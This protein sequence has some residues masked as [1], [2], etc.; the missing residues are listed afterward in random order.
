MQRSKKQQFMNSTNEFRTLRYLH[1]ALRNTSKVATRKEFENKTR[2]ENRKQTKFAKLAH[3]C[4]QFANSVSER[5]GEQE[6]L[7]LHLLRFLVAS[8]ALRVA[9]LLRLAL[10]VAICNSKLA[11]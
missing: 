10:Q 5:L 3:F 4:S 1:K 6:T 2:V 11:K 8:L 7:L 9:F